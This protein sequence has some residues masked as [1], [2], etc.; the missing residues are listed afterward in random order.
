[1]SVGA[2]TRQYL[3]PWHGSMAE[4]VRAIN[5][6]ESESP[7]TH[8]TNSRR[9]IPMSLSLEHARAWSRHN[10]CMAGA[11]RVY[12]P[13]IIRVYPDE[14]SMITCVYGTDVKYALR[15]FVRSMLG[16]VG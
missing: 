15:T 16:K 3:G 6:K 10:V 1:M 2:G 7:P 8:N 9:T 5:K 12:F 13:L 11:Q 4:A 14:N